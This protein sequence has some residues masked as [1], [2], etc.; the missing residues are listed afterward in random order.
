MRQPFGLGLDWNLRPVE[1]D[2][3][4]NQRCDAVVVGVSAKKGG[5]IVEPCVEPGM[6]WKDPGAVLGSITEPNRLDCAAMKHGDEVVS[7]F[8]FRPNDVGGSRRI[9]VPPRPSA[10]NFDRLKRR[11]QAADGA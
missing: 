2:Q 3:A 4:A 5:H 8:A 9:A 6:S 7:E 1:Q 10:V 11:S